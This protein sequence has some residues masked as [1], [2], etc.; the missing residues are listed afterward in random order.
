MGNN[1][2]E[3]CA[4]FSK[5]LHS[6]DRYPLSDYRNL[7]FE[8]INRI[9]EQITNSAQPEADS[10]LFFES[11]EALKS[12][13][14]HQRTREKPLG[15]AGDFLLIDW[16]YTQKTADSGMGKIFDEMFHTYEAAK[17]V[18]NRKEYFIKKCHELRSALH[19]RVDVLDIGSGSCRDVLEA[20]TVCNNGTQYYFH[21]I[22]HEPQAIDYAKNL[23]SGTEAETYV[24]LE[25]A[26]A[27]KFRGDRKYDLIWSAGLFDYLENRLAA[28]L[29]KKLWRYLKDG[30]K[31]IFGNFSPKNPIRN[32][33]E[34][35]GQ[36]HLIH[37]SAHE[38]IQI[39]EAAGIPYTSLEVEAE[40][41]G[42]NLFC[43]ITK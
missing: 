8:H 40:E 14:L 12:S 19:S 21:C 7:F 29:I 30:G 43:I 22:D 32:G 3:S 13:L 20:H 34:L 37:R 17:A 27:F 35:V 10:E 4:D 15:Y 23:L 2:Q 33:M 28:L 26:N 41:L 5:L 25:C 16:I 38:L 31:F 9:A 11:C 1:I 6:V 42:I 39:G 24:N 18:R 36:W